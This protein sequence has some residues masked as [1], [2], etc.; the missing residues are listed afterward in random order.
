MAT[1]YKRNDEMLSNKMDNELI[2]LSLQND[3][4]FGLN[5][6]GTRIWELLEKPVTLD[7][8]T[9]KLAG[10]YHIAPETCRK[11]LASFIADMTE[12]KLITIEKS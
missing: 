8:L 2:L 11:E 3:R 12:K 5:E 4:Y 10:E 9:E 7:E 1:Q 6:V